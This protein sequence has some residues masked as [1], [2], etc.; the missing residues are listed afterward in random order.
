ME[1]RELATALGV[2]SYPEALEAV[3]QNLDTSDERICDEAFIQELHEKYDLL[4]EYYDIVLEGARDLKTKENLLTW[5]KLAYAYAKDASRRDAALMPM[6]PSDGSPAAEMLPVLALIREVPD[7]ARRYADRGFDE[8]KIKENLANIRI[9][10]WVNHLTRGNVSLSQGLYSWLPFYTK[11]LMFDHKGFNYQPA[12]WPPF[13]MVL[14]NKKSGEYVILMTLGRFTKD[15]LVLESVGAREED[16]AFDAD[17]REDDTA[18]FGHRSQ[19]GRVQS[20][21]EAFGKDEW[22]A[23][24]RHGDFVLNL[25]IPR[26]TNLNP[27]NVTESFGEALALARKHYPEFFP[28]CIM[29]ET[30]LLDPKLVTILGENTKL[31]LF[32][33]R[34]LK[35]PVKDASGKACLGFVWPG[36]KG[37]VSEYSE[38]TTLQRG[39]K[40]LLLAGDYIR[41][42]AGI[43]ADDL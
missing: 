3:Y 34:F 7:A 23:V 30:W 32:S 39:I 37:D 20:T 42:T 33:S 16:G 12:G 10:M 41:N 43:V 17:F 24:L 36:E 13:S 4:G 2:A 9:N 21:L 28:K 31:S 22:E 29:C 8:E 18:F 11:A 25:H 19:N 14:K 27:Q 1:L 5:G 6:P 40:Q 35:H 15:G 38:K 26:N